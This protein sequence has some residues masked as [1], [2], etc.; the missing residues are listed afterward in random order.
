LAAVASRKHSVNEKLYFLEKAVKIALFLHVQY[1]DSSKQG[2][3]PDLYRII[4]LA[5][6]T[7][8]ALS[9]YCGLPKQGKFSWPLHDNLIY[10]LTSVF[11]IQ[12]LTYKGELDFK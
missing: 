6:L 3:L 4:V 2:Q 12:R 11:V 7:F 10:H 1:G 5:L 8:L 9:P